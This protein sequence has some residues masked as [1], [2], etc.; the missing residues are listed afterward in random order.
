MTNMI[1]HAD[2]ILHCSPLRFQARFKPKR[3]G[4]LD[5]FLRPL[6]GGPTVQGEQ[7]RTAVGLEVSG[8]RFGVEVLGGVRKIGLPRL[9]PLPI[10]LITLKEAA[11][12]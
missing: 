4:L 1:F 9:P 10:M 8:K 5:I 6:A 7:L 3:H 11:V 2:F 12:L